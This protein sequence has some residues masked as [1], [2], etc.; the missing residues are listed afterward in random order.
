MEENYE[1]EIKEIMARME[2]PW[3][4]ACCKSN[5]KPRCEVKDV[6]LKHHLEIEGEGDYSCK[7][8]VVSN[9]VHYCKCPLCIYLTKRLGQWDFFTG[10]KRCV[11]QKIFSSKQKAQ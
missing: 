11:M 9:G 10:T 8:L 7:F 3:D 2:C 5:L 6:G 4:F 1:R